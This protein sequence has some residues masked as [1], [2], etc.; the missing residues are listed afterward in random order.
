MRIFDVDQIALNERA[1]ATEHLLPDEQVRAAFRSAT[2][3]V[4]F[5]ERRILTVQLHTLLSERLETSS[6][7]YRSVRQFSILESA[8]GGGRSEIR[9]WLGADPQPLHLRANAGT[10]LGALQRLLAEQTV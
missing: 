7:S 1:G 10:E 3:T 2:T 5:T 9:I 4:L 8:D 6:Y